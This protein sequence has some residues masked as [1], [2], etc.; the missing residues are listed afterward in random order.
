MPCGVRTTH[1][2]NDQHSSRW[3]VVIPQ[4]GHEEERQKFYKIFKSPSKANVRFTFF[5]FQMDIFAAAICFP[6]GTSPEEK[7]TSLDLTR[8]LIQRFH[9]FLIQHRKNM[10]FLAQNLQTE[11]QKYRKEKGS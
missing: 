8:F 11:T 9:R 1:I 3:S 2:I 7:G 4:D 6:I 10:Y 5:W